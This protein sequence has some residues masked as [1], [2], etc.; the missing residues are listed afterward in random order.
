ML[1][2][3]IAYVTGATGLVGS[4]LTERLLNE[5]YRVRALVLESDDPSRLK[6]LGAECIPGDITDSS[7]KLRDGIVGATHVFHCAAWVD[8]W[9][10]RDKMVRVNVHGLQN[11]LEAVRGMKLR[12]FLFI[13]SIMV[14]GDGD[15]VNANESSRFVRTGDNYNYTKIECERILWEFVR[16][17]QLSAV[18][19]RPSYIYGERDNQFL[20]RVCR[21]LLS[22]E[23]IY[24]NGGRIPFTL[25]DVRNVVDACLLAAAR[26]EA[27]GEGFI[28]TD[29]E[30]VT[31]RELVEL[32]CDEVGYKR[33]LVSLPRGFGI[34]MCPFA[35]GLAKFMNWKRPFL[36]NRFLCHFAGSHL[37]FDI[38]KARRLLGY[39]PKYAPRESLRE[40][41]RWFKENRPDLL[42]KRRKR[43]R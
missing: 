35:V 8:D 14:Y 28:I 33:P 6:Q 15:L 22:R 32:V 1:E 37:T 5:G 40:A 7:G 26:E 18:V 27:V 36:V 42:P 4:H 43:A 24:V 11:L 38:S 19:L 34:T 9:A 25:S 29:S 13:G 3:R 16:Q 39:E 20:P 21:A 23:W 10:P 2:D 12:R 30:P 41:V 31:R 17:T